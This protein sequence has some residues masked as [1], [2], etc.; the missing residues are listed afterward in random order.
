MSRGICYLVGAHDNGSKAMGVVAAI[1]F[2][3]L[4]SWW[5]ANSRRTTITWAGMIIVLIGV[6]PLA[7]IT[8]FHPYMLLAVAQ[9]LVVFPVMLIGLVVIGAGNYWAKSSD[10]SKK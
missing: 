3:S 10:A 7:V 8:S 4:A 5:F 2:L 1:I 9:T 6:T